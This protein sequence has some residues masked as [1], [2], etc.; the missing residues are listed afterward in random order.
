MQAKQT[1]FQLTL[2]SLEFVRP[3][4]RTLIAVTCLALLLATLSAVDPLVM[5]YLFD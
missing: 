5:K 4:R 3:Y 1:T 2:R